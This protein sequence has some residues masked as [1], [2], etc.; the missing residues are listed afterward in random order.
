MI[1]QPKEGE[2]KRIELCEIAAKDIKK[3]FGNPRKIKSAELKK[4]RQSFENFG[5][6]GIFVVDENDNI[7]AGNQRLSVVMDIAPETILTCK[8]LIG[9]TEAELR[10]INIKANTHAGEWDLDLLAKWTADL[11]VDLGIDITDKAPDKRKLQDLEPIRYEKYNYI[12]IVCNNEIDYLN[13]SRLFGLDKSRVL[14]AKERRIK[15][16]AVWFDSIRDILFG[17]GNSAAS[18]DQQT[19]TTE[20]I[21]Q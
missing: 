18:D 11:N 14:I 1:I 9:Y 19:F 8:R 20:E 17:K 3:G 15:A 6:F 7:I 12:M 2:G 10:A 5:D 21:D 16:R 13:L 4:L